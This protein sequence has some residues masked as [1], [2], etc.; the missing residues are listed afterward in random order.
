M[1]I[2]VFTYK[3]TYVILATYIAGIAGA[4][5]FFIFLPGNSAN[6]VP[7]EPMANLPVS[8]GTA[9]VAAHLRVSILQGAW[10][11]FLPG[12]DRPAAETGVSH[13]TVSRGV[14]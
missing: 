13:M 1:V 10:R 3:P 12:R 14:A 11:D 2:S 6:L 7:V 5:R 8:T 4:I 9:Q